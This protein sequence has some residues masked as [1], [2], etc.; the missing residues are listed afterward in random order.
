MSVVQYGVV[1]WRLLI[2]VKRRGHESLNDPI[3]LLISKV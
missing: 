3:E 2:E 1:T